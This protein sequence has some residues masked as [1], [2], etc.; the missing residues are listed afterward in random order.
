MGSNH[1][2]TKKSRTLCMLSALILSTFSISMLYTQSASA[3]TA[4]AVLQKCNVLPDTYGRITLSTNVSASADYTV[5]IRM[6]L[7]AANHKILVSVDSTNSAT[8]CGVEMGISG[9]STQPIE[10]WTWV[11]TKAAGGD[12]KANIPAGQAASI[13]IAGVAGS[14]N[15]DIDKVML[16]S[17]NCVPTALGTNCENMPPQTN[18]YPGNLNGDS[19]V[20]IED[21]SILI[22][23][24]RKTGMTWEQGDFSGDGTVN[25]SDLS[26]LVRNWGP[27][28]V[29]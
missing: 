4:P 13:Q 19:N 11:K 23:N 10:Q 20:N 27:V 15:V 9:I 8:S 28:P 2:L 14:N 6:R 7:K 21:L 17:S 25:I 1:S 16:I 18:K 26:I 3:Q 5:W 29:Q 12:M 24:Y 22:A